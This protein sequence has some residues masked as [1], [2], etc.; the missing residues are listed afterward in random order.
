MSSVRGDPKGI[1][2]A[3]RNKSLNMDLRHKYLNTRQWNPV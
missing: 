3:I 2:K 1:Y